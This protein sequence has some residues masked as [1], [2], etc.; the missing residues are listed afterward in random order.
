[1]VCSTVLSEIA[2]PRATEPSV[3]TTPPPLPR[4]RPPFVA[5]V[6][7]FGRPTLEDVFVELA[8]GDS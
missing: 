5:Q 2:T 1:M 8:S 3:P 7:L 4:H 6:G